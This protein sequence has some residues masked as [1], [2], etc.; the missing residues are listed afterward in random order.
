MRLQSVPKKVFVNQV[1]RPRAEPREETH[2]KG[3]GGMVVNS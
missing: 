2:E 1:G 3:E